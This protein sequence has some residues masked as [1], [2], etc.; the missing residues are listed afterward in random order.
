MDTGR[1]S[2]QGREQAMITRR[3][4]LSALA[5]AAS[6]GSATGASALAYNKNDGTPRSRTKDML[7]DGSG[8]GTPDGHPQNHGEIS[9]KNLGTPVLDGAGAGVGAM[10]NAH[11]A[12]M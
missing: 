2:P 6:L 11:G 12:G 5:G 8:G 3:E 1:S 10:K 9:L 4:F 7:R